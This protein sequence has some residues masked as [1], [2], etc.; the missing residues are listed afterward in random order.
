M[1]R[2]GLKVRPPP[3]SW[4]SG[5]SACIYFYIK[6]YISRDTQYLECNAFYFS[7]LLDEAYNKANSLTLFTV[8]MR[9]LQRTS[10]LTTLVRDG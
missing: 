9:R 2:F 7:R 4:H 5:R 6:W 10:P 8:V 1:G 3:V